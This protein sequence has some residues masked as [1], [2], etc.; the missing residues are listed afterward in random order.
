MVDH[1][2][3]DFTIAGIESFDDGNDV[4]SRKVKETTWQHLLQT[5]HPRGI[6]NLKQSYL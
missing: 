3:K 4:L 6:N 5:T 1:S 2:V